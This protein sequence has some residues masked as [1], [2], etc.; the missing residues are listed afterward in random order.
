M[1]TQS[2]TGPHADP[3]FSTRF[4]INRPLFKKILSEVL[5]TIDLSMYCTLYTF[6]SITG[7]PLDV[8]QN[9][10]SFVDSRLGINDSL[11]FRKQ[12]GILLPSEIPM[13]WKLLN[14]ITK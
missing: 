1:S 13:T 2:F 7:T 12:I 14:K 5:T 9:M 3:Y 4:N 8:K 11:K 10:R 6:I